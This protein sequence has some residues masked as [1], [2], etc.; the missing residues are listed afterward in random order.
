MSLDNTVF[1]ALGVDEMLGCKLNFLPL[2]VPK[3][4][5]Y[6]WTKYQKQQFTS[7]SEFNREKWGVGIICGSV[8]DGLEVI[9]VDTKN[10]TTGT[11]WEDL[12]S[13]LKESLGDAY[14]EL[15]IESTVS[16]GKHLFYLC[17]KI[18]GNQKLAKQDKE[19]VIETRGEGG[20]IACAPSPGYEVI[21]GSLLAVPRIT[22]V[23]RDIII[24]TC[25]SFDMTPVAS[26]VV[27][28]KRD[29]PQPAPTGG[30]PFDDYNERGDITSLFER[31]GWTIVKQ[32]GFRILVKR[33][34]QSTAD[35]SG[36][37]HTD[38]K[39]FKSFSTSTDFEA[40][41]G[42][43][44]S[45]VFGV[46]EG[47]TDKKEIYTKLLAEGYGEPYKS[48]EPRTAGRGLTT[49][50]AV[51][52]AVA[53]PLQKIQF[54]YEKG[55]KEDGDEIKTCLSK[56]DLYR[57]L[58]AEGFRKLPDGV[59]AQSFFRIQGAIA[60]E[61]TAT[62][63]RN[64]VELYAEAQS[65]EVHNLILNQRKELS[66]DS[67]KTIITQDLKTTRDTKEIIYF[68]YKNGVVK[69]TKDG[70]E[71][72]PWNDFD[73]V[74]WKSQ[75][76]DRNA[77]EISDGSS[78]F[79]LFLENV[80]PKGTQVEV[81]QTALGK[82]LHRF[83]SGKE[84]KKLL[85]LTDDTDE[86]GSCGQ[87]GKG[88]FQQAIGAMR[89]TCFLN[90]KAWKATEQFSFQTLRPYHE[91]I[92]IDDLNKGFALESLYSIITGEISVEQKG[93][94]PIVINE[95][96]TPQ[97]I[98]SS[99]YAIKSKGGISDTN[100]VHQI[101]FSNHYQKKDIESTHGF[102]FFSGWNEDQ[103]SDFDTVAIECCQKWLKMGIVMPDMSSDNVKERTLRQVCSESFVE[104]MEDRDFVPDQGIE[105][106]ISKWKADYPDNRIAML[107]CLKAYANYKGLDFKVKK[108]ARK[109]LLTSKLPF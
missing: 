94:D 105:F 44:Y 76:L 31:H 38:K 98:A 2:F 39:I 53:E 26:E 43:N 12:E 70:F 54:W 13:K 67:L 83:K 87:R 51:A 68:Y 56:I 36:D 60:Y 15:V 24:E 86:F 47:I 19:V 81:F 14:N 73:G 92:V 77:P 78:G 97:F 69:I 22:P 18:D 49:T 10:D 20:L 29:R 1:D 85:V 16:G 63:V 21:Q 96:D 23:V 58:H 82:S 93:K 66:E 109:Y 106:S 4:T 41:K 30:S 57:F 59:R 88:V 74:V 48:S 75:V 108:G 32:Q 28:V 35:H 65:S 33:P 55:S 61:C 89:S 62:A 5:G 6:A 102:W 95:N 42:Y 45:M 104:W 107:D 11:L 8:S 100:R 103:W 37:I 79:G 101:F 80:T 7:A 3:Y 17:D 52:V 90:G 50:A 25:K 40:E 34:G 71:L 27:P 9:D 64:Y 99:N 91:A 46:L 72:I 84:H